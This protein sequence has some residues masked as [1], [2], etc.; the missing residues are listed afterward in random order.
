MSAATKE[1]SG[2][3]IFRTR[4]NGL[5]IPRG[6]RA[7]LLDGHLPEAFST[8]L[9]GEIE[10]TGLNG[11]IA[12]QFLRHPELE[13]RFM[14]GRVKIDSDPLLETEHMVVPGF[15]HKYEAEGL[16]ELLLKCD[17]YCRHCF[18]DQ[19]GTSGRIADAS[20][21]AAIDY[22]EKTPKLR[23]VIASGGDIFTLSQKEFEYP[24]NA[25]ARL[26]KQ[27]DLDSVRLASRLP[28]HNPDRI[29]E[30]H[31][32][33]V[34]NLNNPY[35]MFHINHYEELQHPKTRAV[36]KKF[37][38]A[39]GRLKGQMVF[40]RGVN[41]DLKNGYG[42]SDM[43]WVVETVVDENGQPHLVVVED[44]SIDEDKT[45]ETL[46]RTFTEMAN[47][48]VDP[49][50]VYQNDPV[51]WAWFYTVPLPQA[52]RIWQRVRNPDDIVG[53]ANTARFVLDAPH[54]YGKVAI[55]EGGSWTDVDVRDGYVDLHGKRHPLEW[56][57]PIE[58]AG[59]KVHYK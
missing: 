40:L 54:G 29:K 14:N 8:H 25:L 44:L 6:N 21:D 45:V 27:G 7:T 30:F 3:G 13:D 49:Y 32:E 26:L 58:L 15:I 34:R 43:E 39:G 5:L 1:I 37:L 57:F 11:P 9:M 33:A 56:P 20:V 23:Q 12:N 53:T 19:M 55:P 47:A 52:Y 18:R 41:A 16:W 22:V 38:E 50:Y 59:V 24:M 46:T 4:E 48:G 36:Y 10:R 17:S 2:V 28:F 35:L 31:Y 42:L 51:P